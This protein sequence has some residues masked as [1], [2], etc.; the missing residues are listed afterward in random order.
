MAQ[1]H[2]GPAFSDSGLL[3]LV[4]LFD[5]LDTPFGMVDASGSFFYLNPA[6]ENLLDM[7]GI[8]AYHSA[9][10]PRLCEFADLEET[11]LFGSSG[12][13]DFQCLPCL[14]KALLLPSD[15]AAEPIP[16]LLRVE[17][18]GRSGNGMTIALC[19][20]Q[21]YSETSNDSSIAH[22][23]TLNTAQPSL[24][25]RW[26]ERIEEIGDSLDI[27]RIG[28]KACKLLEDLAGAHAVSFWW[29]DADKGPAAIPGTLRLGERIG[30]TKFIEDLPEQLNPRDEWLRL[31]A[32]QTAIEMPRLARALGH[33]AHKPLPAWINPQGKGFLLACKTRGDLLGMLVIWGDPSRLAQA[34]MSDLLDL[35]SFQTAQAIDHARWF[36]FARQFSTRGEQM[37]ENANALIL[38]MDTQGRITLWNHKCTEVFGYKPDEALGRLASA[39]LSTTATDNTGL[40]VD[41]AMNFVEALHDNRALADYEATLYDKEGNRHLIVWNTTS[42][43]SPGGTALGSYAIGQDI[44]QRK[45]LEQGLAASER[46]YRTLVEST[47]DLYWA[48]LRNENGGMGELAFLN[49]GFA[50][51]EREE[52]LAGGLHAFQ[53]TFHGKS[54]ELFEQACH[55]VLETG[56]P[57]HH[58]ETE[59][60]TPN[61]A[62][63]S[64]WLLH[65][66]F[67]SYEG[68]ELVGVQGLSSDVTERK[69]I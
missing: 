45:V 1:A 10:L 50:G 42:L 7:S 68:Q 17:S 40:V 19:T 15:P 55:T 38:G 3:R 66:L 25:K 8:A 6:L 13:I 63:P 57:V 64:V 24:M 26:K 14:D 41:D 20:I 69:E 31:V 47:H 43:T 22:P 30:D 65:D 5:P 59:H 53:Q 60:T 51:Q 21:P 67:P 4:S 35:I 37:V 2:A 34:G 18:H 33:N 56:Q 61:A 28:A 49:R 11:D 27:A 52:I 23:S 32:R 39:L 58:L 46:R 16:V 62:T 48:L 29:L 44:T 12:N 9:A 36:L 54:W